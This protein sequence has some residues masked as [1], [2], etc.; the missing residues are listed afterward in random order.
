[1]LF[2]DA[3]G[4]VAAQAHLTEDIHRARR[5]QLTNA[6]AKLVHRDVDGAVD[7]AAGELTGSTDIHQLGIR[8]EGGQILDVEGL[9]GAFDH[10]GGGITGHIH[11]ILGG[12]EGR[13]I[14]QLQ[15]LQ[16]VDGKAVA[17]GGGNLVDAL[18]H[19]LVAGDLAAEDNALRRIDQLDLHRVAAG[20]IAGMGGA[21]GVALLIGD[22]DGLE[23]GLAGA[24]GGSRH[25]EDLGD[26]GALGAGVDPVLAG[27]DVR[28][29]SGLPVGGRS[30][31]DAL[32]L[33]G[34]N[35]PHRDGVADGVDIGHIG[36]QP[37]VH[38]N[39]PAAA[40]LD[41][42]ALQEAGFRP[43]ADAEDDHLRRDP[44][45]VRED[46]AVRGELRRGGVQA[47]ADAFGADV[48]V[49]VVG[50][51]LV[52]VGHDV[53]L[54]LDDGDLYTGSVEVLRHLNAD[55]AAADHRG[56]LGLVLGDIVVDGVGVG[57]VAQSKDLCGVDSLDGR[58]HRRRTGGEHQHIIALGVGLTGGEVFDL[59]A[60]GS[61]VHTEHLIVHPHIDIEP[62]VKALGGLQLQLGLVGD[63]TADVVGQTAVCKGDVRP[64]FK[65]DDL[66]V[67][68][69]AAQ[70][71]GGAG[72]AGHAAYDQYFHEK[73]LLSFPCGKNKILCP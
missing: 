70:T 44:G 17:H 29:Q 26:G 11:R 66:G 65:H 51:I 10:I 34:D 60:L 67:L 38:Q 59:N 23:R 27:D 31:R 21:E 52:Q 36:A 50:H 4:D 16:V 33:T 1:M 28:Y 24:G 12:G 54:S 55:K 69:V 5:V 9:E 39:L 20:V 41:A 19:T 13:R 18:V 7:G 63:H 48:I 25:I 53:A 14:G 61:G 8:R 32:L 71:R 45:A 15:L 68:V 40:E 56:R 47:E 46:D 37:L 3:F 73:W 72:A 6:G 35:I 64:L 43:D 42:A 58:P 62:G 30:Q 22:T 57:D 49:Q 2:G